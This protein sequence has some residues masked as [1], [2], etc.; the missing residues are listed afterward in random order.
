MLTTRK[1]A[2]AFTALWTALTAAALW[3]LL[4]G[5]AHRLPD[6]IAVHWN[7]TTPDRGTAV[8]TFA[9]Q[10][11]GFY[12]IGALT[13]AAAAWY[14]DLERRATRRML[15]AGIGL[16]S[17]IMA[18]AAAGIALAN[19]DHDHWSDARLTGG[20]IALLLALTLAMPAVTA[21]I[22]AAAA[23]NRPDAPRPAPQRT[24][25]LDLP[26]GTR[27]A[28]SHRQGTGISL[29]FVSIAVAALTLTGLLIGDAEA[30][31]FTA[32]GLI[33]IVSAGLLFGGLTVTAGARGVQVRLGLLGW[34]RWR[35]PLSDIDTAYVDERAPADVGG[36]GLRI[37]PGRATAVMIRKG[38][39]LILRRNN[40]HEA[41]ISVDDAATAAAVLNTLGQ[42][43]DTP[44]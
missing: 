30:I 4:I 34:I 10:I 38:E 28:W 44:R 33:V 42:R 12:L 24:P 41:I 3:A 36:W 15:G 17:G 5:L 31:A 18:G 23:G 7:G 29:L 27:L 9:L 16:W 13:A 6:P 32:S 22:G 37:V 43:A 1:H 26:E 40:K 19:L 11:S 35:I 39:C 20:G 2:I 25:A 14:S 8:N 21:L